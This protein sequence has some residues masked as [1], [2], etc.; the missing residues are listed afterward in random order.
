[1]RFCDWFHWIL[2]QKILLK[3]YSR[4]WFVWKILKSEKKC[5]FSVFPRIF[6]YFRDFSSVFI[7]YNDRLN[8]SEECFA[9][10]S[11]LG[12]ESYYFLHVVSDSEAERLQ[13]IIWKKF[14]LLQIWA[15]TWNFAKY[16]V[17]SSFVEFCRVLASLEQLQ[18][19]N[20]DSA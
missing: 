15:V 6:K 11:W 3:I 18:C 19:L 20:S 14:E 4:G 12:Q 8:L 16:R 1:M 10:P 9:P 2:L 13:K 5:I 17:L 7:F